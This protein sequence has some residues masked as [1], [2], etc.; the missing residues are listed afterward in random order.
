MTT[1]LRHAFQTNACEKESRYQFYLVPPPQ[2]P[3]LY[4]QKALGLHVSLRFEL[5]VHH[6][7]S[8]PMAKVACVH[9]SPMDYNNSQVSSSTQEP[10]LLGIMSH[11]AF[12][13]VIRCYVVH[14]TNNMLS[15]SANC[16]LCHQ[17]KE[18]RVTWSSTNGPRVIWENGDDHSIVCS[19]SS[20][21]KAMGYYATWLLCF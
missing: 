5:K 1:L 3:T 7:N 12:K 17:K 13:S 15:S 8:S 18:K 16:A 21:I 9:R 19:H 2:K 20:N 6:L 4:C 14:Q 11:D 10:K